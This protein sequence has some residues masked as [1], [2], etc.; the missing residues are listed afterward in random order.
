MDLNG[1]TQEEVVS[2][3]RATPMGGAVGL[4]VLRQEDPF[5]PREVVSLSFFAASVTLLNIS[6]PWRAH[7][8]SSC[9][10]AWCCM[11]HRFAANSA[12]AE[13]ADGLSRRRCQ[14][15]HYPPAALPQRNPWELNLL[16]SPSSFLYL[17]A[18]SR[19]GG[20]SGLLRTPSSLPRHLSSHLLLR[21]CS[22]RPAVFR[23]QAD[24][25]D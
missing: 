6:P 23:L 11:S 4:L 21:R 9:S 25:R 16:S 2:L 12:L 15:L 14:F 17:A 22:F 3:L 13:H 18:H 5:V 7:A 8:A 20:R 1:R 24:W 19:L 10:R